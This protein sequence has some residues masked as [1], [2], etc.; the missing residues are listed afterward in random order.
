MYGEVAYFEW[1]DYAAFSLMLIISMAIG[2]YF[3]FWKKQDNKEEYLLGGKSMGVI[4]VTISLITSTVSGI[5]VMAYPADVYKYGSITLWL[6]LAV[7]ING[8]IYAYVF[9]PVYIKA[10]VTSLYEYLEKRFSSASRILASILYTLLMIMYGPIVI[11]IPCLAFNQATGIDVIIVAPIICLLCIF[12]TTIGGIKAVIWTDTFQF[13]GTVVASITIVIVGT[14]SVGGIEKVWETALAG[15]RLDIFNFRNDVSARDTFWSMLFGGAIQ[16]GAY[17][18]ANQGEFQKCR[19]VPSLAKARLCAILYGIGVAGLLLLT[20]LNGNIMYTKY[21]N[22]DPLTTHQVNRDDQLLAYFVLDISK[23]VPGL[24]G[25][26]VAGVFCAALST[27]S[28]TLNTTAGIIYE[29]FLKRFLSVETQKTREGVILKIL[30]LCF[31]IVSTSLVLV[32]K[33][34]N[35]IV[36]LVSTIQGIIYSCLLGLLSLGVLVPVANAKGALCGAI[37]TLLVVSCLGFGR[38]YY[39]FSGTPI[40]VSKPLSVEGCHFSYNTTVAKNREDVFV[41]FRVTFWYIVSIGVFTTIVVGTIISLLTR[42]RGEVVDKNLVSPI[43][44]RFLR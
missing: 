42:K 15:E 34:V 29:D 5:T 12:Y 18:L 1:Y 43:L 41:I 32:V 20:I 38:L 26:F 19:S 24:P 40:E 16:W 44:H 28:A 6:C 11:Y 36:P 9:L 30:V 13:I 14:A 25:I 23:D 2:T 21:S 35:E 7:P 8:F 33:I 39:M 17:V 31:G 27:Y 3:G 37:T 22:C 10:E 4:P